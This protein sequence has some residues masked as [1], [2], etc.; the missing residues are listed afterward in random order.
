[1]LCFKTWLCFELQL[2][3]FE[4]LV[5]TQTAVGFAVLKHWISL[6]RKFMA[7]RFKLYWSSIGTLQDVV[8]TS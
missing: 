2:I 6:P 4:V 1:M 5:V 8:S 3:G 7:G